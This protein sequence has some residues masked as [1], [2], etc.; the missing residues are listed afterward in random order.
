MDLNMHHFKIM[1]WLSQ[2]WGLTSWRTLV[3]MWFWAKMFLVNSQVF[4]SNLLI[5]HDSPLKICG[6][7]ACKC[8]LRPYFRTSLPNL[9][10]LSISQAGVLQEYIFHPCWGEQ[11]PST[12]LGKAKMLLT[13]TTKRRMVIAY[14]TTI[15][16]YHTFRCWPSSSKDTKLEKII[17][18]RYA[19]PSILVVHIIGFSCWKMRN[20]IL[21]LRLL[22]DFINFAEFHLELLMSWRIFLTNYRWTYRTWTSTWNFCIPR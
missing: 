18:L 22:D 5:G 14:F 12:L 2:E 6:L 1:I 8:L 4:Y 10:Q 9:N 19:A 21:L 15:K 13:G 16:S 11:T 3:L 20:L 17:Y 7:S